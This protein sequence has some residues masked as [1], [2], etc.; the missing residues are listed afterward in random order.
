MKLEMLSV[1]CETVHAG[2]N[3]AVKDPSRIS[4]KLR[5]GLQLNKSNYRLQSTTRFF[6]N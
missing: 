4:K 1:G 2:M 6:L 3:L 5:C